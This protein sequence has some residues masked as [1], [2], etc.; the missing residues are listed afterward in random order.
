MCAHISVLVA[1]TR[2]VSSF[3]LSARI[4]EAIR[5]SMRD[6]STGGPLAPFAFFHNSACTFHFQIAH[7]TISTRW[8]AASIG[9]GILPVPQ[10]RHGT[11]AF[12][13]TMCRKNTHTRVGHH[14][15][16]HVHRKQCKPLRRVFLR[17]C[18]WCA[19]PPECSV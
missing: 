2:I 11:D 1:A 18:E 8:C 4:S 5:S 6:S 12:R 7:A 16:R 19:Y 3:H 13:E 17:T 9:Y 14:T 10:N 15:F